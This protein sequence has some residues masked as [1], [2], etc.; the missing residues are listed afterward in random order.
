[1]V[2][3]AAGRRELVALEPDGNARWSLAR[4]G[5][6]RLARW[7][8]TERDT[9]V[10]YLSGL[11]LRVVAGDGADDRLLSRRVR[12]VA[13]A[14][15]PGP[16]HVLT[17]VDAGGAIVT[18]DADT[19]REVWRRRPASAVRELEWA[20]DGRVLLVRGRRSLSLLGPD[21]R[22]RFD[23][24]RPPAAPVA[25]AA[26]AGRGVAFVQW[27]DGGSSLWIVPRLAPDGSAARRVFEGAGRVDAVH[28]SPDGRWL[29]LSWPTA[30]QWLFVRARG[31]PRVDGA[32]GIRDRFG[33]PTAV[34]GWCCRR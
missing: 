26:F 2:A 5:P 34:A 4:P 31:R 11:Q 18:V 29:L 25:D 20:A 33:A 15:R 7:G 13:P 12:R 21:G 9:R 16:A 17:Y 14:W 8:G 19:A 30:D 24:L 3:V 10:A 22:L 23:L 6:L 28:P 32:S 27:A 1:V